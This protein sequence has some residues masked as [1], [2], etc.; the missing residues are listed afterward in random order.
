MAHRSIFLAAGL[1][2]AL[3]CPAAASAAPEPIE[4]VEVAGDGG[5]FYAAPQVS[6][7]GNQT[8]T[9]EEYD[10]GAY[11]LRFAERGTRG[12][13][14]K[15]SVLWSDTGNLEAPSVSFTPGGGIYAV[16][17]ISSY[18]ASAEQTFRPPGGDFTPRQAA[19]GCGR[20]VDSAA[21]PDGGI[22]LA[23]SHTLASNPPDTTSLGT[24]PL[25]GPV[26]VSE[27][28]L[29]PAYDPYVR[30]YVDWGPEGTVAVVS[31]GRTTTVTP[32]PANETTRIRVSLRSPTLAYTADV[33]QAT[34]PNEVFA[35]R[36]VVLN[37]G[38]V[39]V[40]LSG[41]AGARLL[42]RPPGAATSFT[43]L[44][45]PGDG[46]GGISLDASESLH[47][48][49]ANAEPPNREYWASSKPSGGDFGTPF[50]IP[51]AGSGDPYIPFDSFRVAADG[52]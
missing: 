9:W 11:S 25:L 37:D 13:A 29:P 46:I 34:W 32:P 31:R 8:V 22:A 48:I 36:P 24:S 19:T 4:P 3:L 39:A 47:L 33:D 49:S 35:T 40:G 10:S 20:F 2:C 21:G 16:W 27:D 30:P 14:F 18:G 12:E 52:T 1:I 26:T 41:S 28:L 23:C 38:T 51:L 7:E 42:I 6:P 15:D 5:Y 45:L 17:G 50:A 43:S 44:N